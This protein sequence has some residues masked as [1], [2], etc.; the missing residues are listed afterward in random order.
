[1][2]AVRKT[3]VRIR[4][5][6]QRATQC[7]AAVYLLR[8]RGPDHAAIRVHSLPADETSTESIYLQPYPSTDGMGN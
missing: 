8:H 6:A 3:Q 4:A 2:E 1:M 7:E 5:V